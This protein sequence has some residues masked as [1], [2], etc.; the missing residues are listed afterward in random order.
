MHRGS[1]ARWCAITDAGLALI[2]PLGA[3]VDAQDDFL[4]GLLGEAELTRLVDY[5]DRIR[6]HANK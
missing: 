5:L 1:T 3:P 4:L 6:A 2:E